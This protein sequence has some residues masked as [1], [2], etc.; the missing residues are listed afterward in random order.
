MQKAK[1][2]SEREITSKEKNDIAFANI[3][4]FCKYMLEFGA[5]KQ[6]LLEIN[7]EVYKKY[8]LSQTLINN[9]NLFLGEK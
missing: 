7:E 3:L 2:K 8:D 9:I 4:P 1:K 6:T 5:S